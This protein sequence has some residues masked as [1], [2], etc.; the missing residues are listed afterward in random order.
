MET[1]SPY[2]LAWRKPD[3]VHVRPETRRTVLEALEHEFPTSRNRLSAR[4]NL[5]AVTIRHAC[6]QLIR[7]RIL[8]L[9]YGRDPDSGQSCDLITYVRYPVLPVLELSET[10]MIW[11]LC[12][13]LS[14]S[15]FATVRDRGGFCT[16][17]DDLHTLMGQVSAILRA[18]TCRLPKDLPLQAPILL[19]PSP[20]NTP[21]ASR[22]YTLPRT[23]DRITALVGHVLDEPPSFM[24][25]PEEAV[26][27]ELSYHPLAQ[28]ASCVLHLR[29]GVAAAATLLIRE[30]STNPA[31]PL[32]VAPY[33]AAMNETLQA[34]L[35]DAPLR[36]DSW[37]NGVAAFLESFCRLMTPELVVI[38]IPDPLPAAPRI[39]EVLPDFTALQWMSYALNTPS[40]AHKGALRQARRVLWA[41]LG[42]ASLQSAHET[43][44][45]HVP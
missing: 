43:G 45:H 28:G 6:R 19:L 38:E 18:G 4:A 16:A 14:E 1:I 27:H 23:Q 41:S 5:G 12:D 35:G 10:Y 44:G 40:L 3:Q 9:Q 21:A 26:A 7:E 39:Q 11:R 8:A 36:S 2:R 15:V 20:M 24:L 25:T 42:N 34:T 13:T 17:E 37:Q 31:G 33:A 30:H 29:F 32:A 22:A